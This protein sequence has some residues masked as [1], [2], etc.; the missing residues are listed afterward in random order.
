GWKTAPTHAPSVSALQPQHPAYVIYTSG[1]TGR[2]KGVVNTHAGIDNR[3]QWMQQALQLQPEQ[4]VLQKTPVG[5]DVSVWELFWP[6]RVGARLVL[7]QPGGHKDPAYLIDLIEQASIDTAHF[8]PSMLRVFLDALPQ[9]ACTSLQ[10][11]VCSGEALPADLAAEARARLPH[12]RLYNLYG[13][14][15]AAVDVSVWECTDADAHSVPIGRPIANTQLHVLDAQCAL[16]PIG[17]SGELHIAGVQLARGYLGRPD[18]TAERFV[19]DPSAEQPGQRMYR[20]G[21]LAR[22]RADGAL[23]YLGRN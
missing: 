21:D 7:A 13:P 22:W 1:S 2:P 5:F 17:V 9:G 8:V 10:R 6:L 20:T 12:A 23:D 3:L 4:R 14:T 19:P 18:L 16:A 11:I 15:E